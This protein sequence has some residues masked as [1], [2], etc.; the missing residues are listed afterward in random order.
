MNLSNMQ[1]HEP[2]S[3]MQ[4]DRARLPPKEGGVWAHKITTN[5]EVKLNI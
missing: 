5:R 4:Y 2:L 1:R 3:N